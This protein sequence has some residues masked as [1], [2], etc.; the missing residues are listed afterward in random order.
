MYIII[1]VL[2]HG[3]GVLEFSFVFCVSGG[4][5][6]FLCFILAISVNPCMLHDVFKSELDGILCLGND[7]GAQLGI[8]CVITIQRQNEVIH[9]INLLTLKTLYIFFINQMN[10]GFFFNL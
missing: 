5:V 10:K 3:F 6:L 2:L 7:G 4:A 1:S 9:C 8:R